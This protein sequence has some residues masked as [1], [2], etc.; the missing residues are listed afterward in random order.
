MAQQA[1]DF[2]AGED[3][4]D[5]Y[6]LLDG[7]YLDDDMEFNVEIDAV[8]S[9]VTVVDESV[10]VFKCNQCEKV[11]KS[12]RGLT[13]HTNTKHVRNTSALNDPDAS[14]FNW[15]TEK[16]VTSL[17]KLSPANLTGI[18]K[19]CVSIVSA[20]MC[21]PESTRICFDKVTFSLQEANIIWENLRPLIDSFNGSPE[22]FYAEFYGLMAENMMPL[23]FDDITL[24]NIL[25]SEV[26]NHI[27]LDL[28]GK[29]TDS[30]DAPKV[31]S[32]ITDKE[33]KCLQYISAVA[34]LY[35]SYI[36]NLDSA[37]TFLLVNIKYNV[38]T[39]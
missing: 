5:L 8:V 30:C 1:G 33:M 35:T 37:K 6:Y 23:K 7:G 11:C 10:A 18:L 20:D 28:S 21:L 16:D 4:D 3:L 9:E 24:T 34:T 31:I 39:F 36:T 32:Y 25:M 26:A 38:L 12:K 29:N 27:L 17:K 14:D 13:R 19:S 2:L 15:L 22:K